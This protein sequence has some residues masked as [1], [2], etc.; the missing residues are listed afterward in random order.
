M[1]VLLSVIRAACARIRIDQI[2][3]FSWRYLA[4]ISLVQFLVVLAIK[5]GGVV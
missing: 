3:T 4:P 5:A 2:V 1:V